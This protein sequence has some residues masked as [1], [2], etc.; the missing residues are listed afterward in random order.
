MKYHCNTEARIFRDYS[1]FESLLLKWKKSDK[2]IVF[3]NGCFD[4]LHRGHAEYLALAA[5]RGDRLIVGLNSDQSVSRLK[6]SGRPLMDQYSRAWLLA[7]LRFVS[8]VVI[9]EEDTPAEL[10]EVI[11]PDLLIKGG[12]YSTTDIAGNEW[13]ISHGGKVE[14]IGLVPGLSTTSLIRKINEQIK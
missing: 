6:G 1:H 9:F 5:E 3:T 13:V 7:S 2:T 11:S 8:A 14:T 4:L 10:I 12:D